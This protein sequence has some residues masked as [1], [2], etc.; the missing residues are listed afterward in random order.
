[1]AHINQIGSKELKKAEKALTKG[2]RIRECNICWDTEKANAKSWRQLGN[3]FYKFYKL[4]IYKKIELFFDNTCD[5]KCI[6]CN[7]QYSS[8]WLAE[9]K[10]TKH[11]PPNFSCSNKNTNIKNNNSEKIFDYI[12][13]VGNTQPDNKITEIVLLGGEPM[14]TTV[15]KKNLL[16]LCITSFYKNTNHDKSLTIGLQ[17]N[18]NTPTNLLQKI[19]KQL[20]D[21]KKTYKNL[22]VYISVSGESTGK[23]YEYVRHGSSYK[24]YVDNLNT[25]FA[26]GFTISTNMSINCVSI[27]DTLSYFKFF[28]DLCK[29]YNTNGVYISANIVYQPDALSIDVLDKRF[30][31]YIDKCIEYMSDK[32]DVIANLD[33]VIFNLNNFKKHIGTKVDKVPLTVDALNYFTLERGIHFKDVT[34][35]LF[36]YLSEKIDLKIEDKT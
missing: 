36:N 28:I 16:E 19:I 23:N 4:D 8:Q 3:E 9:L 17:T 29:K 6:Y 10:T 35:E 21:Y 1:M 14:L 2:R 27:V 12:T 24:Q 34:P 31:V 7:A 18:C 32:H 13:S 26:A 5:S 22:H 20:G 15:N 25:W 30:L 33:E 11:T